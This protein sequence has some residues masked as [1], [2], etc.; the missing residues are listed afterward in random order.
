MDE[1]LKTTAIMLFAGCFDQLTG[2]NP[3]NYYLY[4]HQG[5]GRW[6][7]IPWDLDVGFA[8][9]AFGRLPVLEG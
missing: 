2:W 1:F 7:Y 8:D 9:R 4:R 3:H 6:S 5:T